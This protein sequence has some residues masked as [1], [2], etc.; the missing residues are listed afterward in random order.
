MEQL[1]ELARER[2][3]D[4]VGAAYAVTAWILVQAAS[5]A[6]PAFD[7]PPA[8]LRWLI[9][10]L[11]VGFP[12]ALTLTW[13]AQP[14]SATVLKPLSSRD[15]LLFS[16]IGLVAVLLA[17]QLSM[18]LFWRSGA[19][20][21][22]SSATTQTASSIAVLPF[23][24]LSGDPSKVYFSD[25]IADQL[26]TELAQTPSLRVAARSSSFSFRGKDVDV[27]TVA[28]AL[29]VRAVLEGSVREAGNRVR[30]AAELVDAANGFQIWSQSYDRDLTNI[31]SLQDEIAHSITEAVAQRFLGHRVAARRAPA[32]GR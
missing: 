14:R 12:L 16:L 32:R 20:G 4:R 27:K 24:N 30:I 26:I 25:G 29:G 5:I 15:W 17:V 9:V 8:A 28:R 22:Q 7:A 18:G 1:L 3:L 6:F 23:A 13:F 21:A 11:I 31:L 10:A 2:K 19:P